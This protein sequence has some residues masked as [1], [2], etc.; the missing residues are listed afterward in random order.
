MVKSFVTKQGSGVK[1]STQNRSTPAA[2][3]LGGAGWEAMCKVSEHKKNLLPP[4]GSLKKERITI[5]KII[6]LQKGKKRFQLQNQ[7]SPDQEKIRTEEKMAKNNLSTSRGLWDPDG[8]SLQLH[9][10]SGWPQLLIRPLLGRFNFPLK[11]FLA[12]TLPPLH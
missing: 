6:A 4:L 2:K 12:V 5:W 9:P 10:P 11:K 3:A 7:E 1:S 8:H